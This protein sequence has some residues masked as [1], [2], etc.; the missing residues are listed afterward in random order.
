M[1]DVLKRNGFTIID[2]LLPAQIQLLMAA[3]EEYAHVAYEN[4]HLLHALK[5]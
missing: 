2:H 4:I 3:G 5:K 1:N